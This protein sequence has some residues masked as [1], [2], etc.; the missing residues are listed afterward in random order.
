MIRV[1]PIM[2]ALGGCSVMANSRCFTQRT[3]V[4]S[5]RELVLAN[6]NNGQAGRDIAAAV[7][8]GKIDDVSVMIKRDNRLFTTQAIYD[9][10]KFSERPQGQYGDLL[11]FAISRCDL[12]MGKHLLDLEM[13]VNGA[14]IGSALTVAL[15]ADGPE[16]AELLL[17]RG[18][19]PDPQKLGGQNAM[20]EITSF[21]QIGGAMMLI[22]HELDLNW[23]NQFGNGHLQTAVDMEQYQIAE[24]LIAK[25]A[26]PW[27]ISG[28]ERCLFN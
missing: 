15:L 27:Q 2:L 4:I 7:F 24:V 17:Q 26:N 8:D 9:K 1:L 16:M 10:S 25:G 21:S 22:R 14:Q 19:S 13:S 20:R 5:D 11:S 18:A 6:V 28:G 23:Q 3:V 12:A